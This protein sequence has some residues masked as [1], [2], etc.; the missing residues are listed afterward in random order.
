MMDYISLPKSL[1]RHLKEEEHATFS[2]ISLFN[3]K[4]DKLY[5]IIENSTTK[6]NTKINSHIIAANIPN[7]KITNLDEP[8][9]IS[10]NLIDQNAANPQCVYWD[11]SSEHWSTKGCYISDY[12]PGKKVLCSCYHLTSFAILMDVYG[13]DKNKGKEKNS[14]LLSIISNVGCIISFVCLILTVI[15][16]AYFKTL[17]KLIASKILVNLCSSLAATY[18]IF[19]VGFQEYI[20]E[21]TAV[22]RAVAAL[23]HY[24]LL[25]SFMWMIVEAIHIYLGLFVF[26][27]IRSSFIKRSSILVWGLPIVIVIITL[28]ISNT[29]NYIRIEKVCW[30]SKTAF[31]AA[32]LAPVAI[33][34]LFNIT[35]FF[36]VMWRLNSLQNDKKFVH[37]T[38]KVRVFGVVGLCFLLGLPWVLAFFAFDEAAEVFN[39]LFTIFN[40]LQGMFIFICYCI[41]KKDTRDV[42]CLFV[43]KRKTWRQVPENVRSSISEYEI[44]GKKKKAET[45]F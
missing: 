17:W 45:T 32:F 35:M 11:K 19:L 16:H 18:L 13:N 22:C 44:G 6:A 2:R 38:K 10:F 37:N 43:R 26:K 15:I 36:V 4:E 3:M 33:I 42:I 8:V 9:S 41:Y 14:E 7:I 5:R 1:I 27:T 24:F 23:L 40:T 31:Y 29:N 30:L 12:E 20:T 21:I 39:H 28:A 25:S 34:L